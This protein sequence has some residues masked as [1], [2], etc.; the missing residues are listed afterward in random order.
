MK[1]H[2]LDLASLVLGLLSVAVAI[3]ALAGRLGEVINHPATAI[4]VGLALLGV[5]VIASARPSPSPTLETLP[6][7]DVVP[8][9]PVD[10]PGS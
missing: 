10:E 9:E 5:A 1:R 3:A 6:A 2:R 7:V 4:P 8:A